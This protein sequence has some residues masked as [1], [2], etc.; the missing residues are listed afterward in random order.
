MSDKVILD[1]C[2]GTGAWSK[3]YKEAGYDVRVIT[4]P[5]HDIRTYKPPINRQKMYTA[6]Y[7]LHHVRCLVW[8]E[9]QQ[10]F[11]ETSIAVWK[12]SKDVWK[13]FGK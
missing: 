10:K 4:L 12:L 8:H 6:Y 7:P 13:L 9:Q 5:K 2:G 1:L 3:P 11:Q